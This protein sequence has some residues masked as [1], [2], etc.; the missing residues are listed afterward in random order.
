MS[1]AAPPGNETPPGRGQ[2]TQWARSKKLAGEYLP[3]GYF[4]SDYLS[5]LAERLSQGLLSPFHCSGC[6]RLAIDP[7]GFNGRGQ[8]LSSDTRLEGYLAFLGSELIFSDDPVGRRHYYFIHR[9][10]AQFRR[11]GNQ[12]DRYQA[13]VAINKACRRLSRA[14]EEK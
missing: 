4:A 8:P 5:L 9:A 3:H 11:S 12:K 1:R 7:I 6:T 13:W 2:A 10:Y 14:R